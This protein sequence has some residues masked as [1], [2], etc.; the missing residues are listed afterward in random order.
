[1][2]QSKWTNP[3][4]ISINYAQ[5]LPGTPLYEYG[6]RTE[7]IGTSVDAEEEYL[8]N[9]SDKNSSEPEY[10]INFTDYPTIVFWSWKYKI[11]VETLYAYIQKFGY[12]QYFMMIN[13][14]SRQPLYELIR[15]DSNFCDTQGQRPSLLNI[16]LKGKFD[17]LLLY[18][19]LVMYR[20]RGGLPLAMLASRMK[21]IGPQ[22]TFKYL[23]E[24]LY[25]LVKPDK[26]PPDGQISKSLRQTVYEDL[27]PVA[28]DLDEMMPLRR[29]R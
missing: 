3:H 29:G 5:A 17:Q 14:E 25:Y 19:P 7:L 28:T 15:V 27:S 24:Y 12:K 8:I 1:M 22:I 13:T 16:L 18:Y 26:N 10:S 9:V 11:Y 21:K 20:F 4:N 23:L 6:R 2:T